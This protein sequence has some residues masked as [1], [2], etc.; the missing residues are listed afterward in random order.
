MLWSPHVPFATACA[1][2]WQH[3]DTQHELVIPLDTNTSNGLTNVGWQANR[4]TI[5]KSCYAAM[6]RYVKIKSGCAGAVGGAQHGACTRARVVVF[7]DHGVWTLATRGP[8]R[9]DTVHAQPRK[10]DSGRASTCRQDVRCPVTHHEDAVGAAARARVRV[11]G[12]A[13]VAAE[14]AVGVVVLPVRAAVVVY[15]VRLLE[16]VAC[17]G[18]CAQN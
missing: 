14:D 13:L 9:S 16:V 8:L 11:A 10:H 1:R 6:C 3:P 18:A 7:R 5:R 17:K 4:R 12:R 2:S 15:E